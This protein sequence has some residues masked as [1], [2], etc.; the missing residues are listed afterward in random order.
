MTPALSSG[1][2]A[3]RSE[4]KAATI[5]SLEKVLTRFSTAEGIYSETLPSETST[6]SAGSIYTG[7]RAAMMKY[8]IILYWSSE[9]DAFIAEVPE[10]AG[11]A[12]DGV[13]RQEAL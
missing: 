11:C 10:L 2:S 6:Q 4:S 12:A 5:S 8:E 7:G 1:G 13:R 9:D 3:S